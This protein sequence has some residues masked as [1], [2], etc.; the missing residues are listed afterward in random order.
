[1]KSRDYA[2]FASA[3]VL[4]FKLT[5]LV[6][7]EGGRAGQARIAATHTATEWCK[8]GPTLSRVDLHTGRKMGGV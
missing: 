6:W 4:W 8:G 3:R 1:M 5:R 2:T 7:L